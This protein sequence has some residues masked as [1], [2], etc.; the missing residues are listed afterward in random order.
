MKQSLFLRNKYVVILS[1]FVL[2]LSMSMLG[3]S[4][5]NGSNGAA[6]AAGANA[7]VTTAAVSGTVQNS[8]G[9][10][11][12]GIQVN[13]Y[14]SVPGGTVKAQSLSQSYQRAKNHIASSAIVAQAVTNASGQY[15]LA[16]L[17]PGTYDI[18]FVDPTGTYTIGAMD[19]QTVTAGQ[20]L[21][22]NAGMGAASST[23]TTVT[24]EAAASYPTVTIVANANTVVDK[25]PANPTYATTEVG[26]G[27]TVTLV[28]QATS[29]VTTS[30]TYAWSA[31]YSVNPGTG[32]P[33]ISAT[34]GTT[35]TVTLP[36]LAQALSGVTDATASTGNLGAGV[37]SYTPE[38][39]I[40]ILPINPDEQGSVSTTVKV[41]DGMGGSTSVSVSSN[42]AM[43]QTGLYDISVG[44][45]VYLNAGHTGTNTW[46]VTGPSGTVTVNAGSASTTVTMSTGGTQ[47]L[48]WFVPTA[49]GTY[50]ATDST[51]TAGLNKITIYA[52]QYLGMISGGGETTMTINPT[53]ITQVKVGGSVVSN[54]EVT[55]T[56]AGVFAS[57][58]TYTTWPYVTVNP[59]CTQCHNG[60]TINGV[61]APDKFTPWKYTAHANFFSRGLNSITSNSGTCLQC[62]TLGYDLAPG[63]ASNGGFGAI[64]ILDSWTY[65]KSAVTAATGK[66]AW[67]T[68]V[69]TPALAN[70]VNLANIQC[71]NCH[72]P[73]NYTGA[74]AHES[75]LAG[76]NGIAAGSRVNDSSEVCGSC[77]SEGGGH[78]KYSEWA[79]T[80]PG[81]AG[82]ITAISPT[83][84][85][86][87][88]KGSGHAKFA[89]IDADGGHAK[90]LSP[91]CSRC[92][93]AEGF[94]TYANQLTNNTPGGPLTGSASILPVSSIVWTAANV[95]T[96]TCTACHDPHSDANPNQLRIYDSVK[97]MTG[98][99]GSGFGKGALC[100]ECHNM[101]YGGTK[102]SV[103]PTSMGICPVNTT[104]RYNLGGGPIAYPNNNNTYMSDYNLGGVPFLHEDTDPTNNLYSA[105]SSSQ[106]GHDNS[107][108]DVLMGR[109]AFFM[110]GTPING[111]SMP[112]YALPML[113]RHAN[114]QD[115][116]VGC[117]MTL[118]PQTHSSHGAPAVS[119]HLFA[120]NDPDRQTLCANCHNNG[121]P[122]VSGVSTPSGD[123]S[124]NALVAQV[125][126]QLNIINSSTAS[127]STV[128]AGNAI[129]NALYANLKAAAAAGL[130]NP[131]DGSTGAALDFYVGGATSAV[132]SCALANTGVV[133]KVS[134]VTAITGTSSFT[135]TTSTGSVTQPAANIL[136]TLNCNPANAASAATAFGLGAI[137]W[138]PAGT[139]P[140]FPFNSVYKRA[141]WNYTLIS[142]DKS[143]GIHNPSFVQAVLNNTI[144][145]LNAASTANTLQ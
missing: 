77:H 124:G 122:T 59:Y 93:T 51:G 82:Q 58:G 79:Q 75:G 113:S 67:A 64:A 90:S 105:G 73:M 97:T 54:M 4:G 137:S 115:S 107:M 29:P 127:G 61:V 24:G 19:N 108:A 103:A 133:V 49:P 104:I 86:A 6:G 69:N 92:H 112:G 57:A 140:V 21:S 138:D 26:Y 95:H 41:S 116:C 68:M 39:R 87:G 83:G 98:L 84:I 35:T 7:P 134:Q 10:A 32:T 131:Y 96:Q 145:A 143:Y 44:Q 70:L 31:A 142:N 34:T 129:G 65:A 78:H 109:N 53:G 72:G 50:V 33:A 128:P 55:G 99:V 56:A 38:N 135:F 120:I 43:V 12:S 47:A 22:I 36:T 66:G 100:M 80:N 85:V 89:Q 42:A 144:A 114:I 106:T 27:N 8:A 25:Y 9:T 71:E 94:I 20:S 60:S 11:L 3:C 101:G 81:I 23:N 88:G 119:D 16:N 63:S 126:S 139:M 15:T 118:N 40:G 28:A 132:T 91:A 48:A 1:V 17:T 13:A 110:S 14:V 30:P 76:Y 52:A 62:H 121:L 45:P 123:V 37:P 141:A 125:Q 136:N 18:D 46:T 111:V 117:H 2:V 130:T 5:S 102:C 74:S